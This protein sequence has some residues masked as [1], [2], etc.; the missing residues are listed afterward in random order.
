MYFVAILPKTFYL[1]KHLLADAACFL[2]SM[3]CQKK[4]FHLVQRYTFFS[5]YQKKS[6]IYSNK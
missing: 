2:K 6:C 3:I 4:N 1:G 5:N